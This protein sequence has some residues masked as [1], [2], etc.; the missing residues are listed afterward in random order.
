MSTD[1]FFIKHLNVLPLPYLASE[2]QLLTLVYFCFAGLDLLSDKSALDSMP[3][4]KCVEWLYSLQTSNGFKGFSSEAND[5][6]QSAHTTMTYVGLLSLLILHDDLTRVHASNITRNV[7]KCQLENGSFV[8]FVGSSESDLRFMFS[9]IAVLTILND[10]K[11]I[12]MEKALEY[13]KSC[14]SYDGGYGQNPGQESHGGSTYCAL[15]SL[16]LMGEMDKSDHM[17]TVVWCLNRQNGG[18]QGR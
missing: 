8:P 4:D 15:A 17:D 10:L 12:N 6:P 3:V 7:V 2:S 1:S 9:A 18:F 13:I 5:E 16:V 11:S 14:K